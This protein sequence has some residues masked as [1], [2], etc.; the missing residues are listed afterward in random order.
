M[1]DPYDSYI[2]ESAPE[3]ED[4]NDDPNYGL[5]SLNGELHIFEST[6]DKDFDEVDFEGKLDTDSDSNEEERYGL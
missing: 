2:G 1:W 6:L 3:P 4:G 5:D